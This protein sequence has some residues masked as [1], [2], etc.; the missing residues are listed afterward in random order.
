MTIETTQTAIMKHKA[1]LPYVQ[2]RVNVFQI[3]KPYV[4]STKAAR[5]W[6]G[7]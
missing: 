2:F 1:D 5:L 6:I 4:S 7:A 3:E